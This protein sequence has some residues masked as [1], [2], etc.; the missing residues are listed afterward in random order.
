[1]DK[2]NENIK[3]EPTPEETKTE[4]T[5]ETKKDFNSMINDVSDSTAEMDAKDIE[6]GKVMGILSYLG[7]L[8]LIPYFA[9]KNNKFVVFH[10]KEGLNLLIISVIFTFATGV[11][12]AIP[13]IGLISLLISWVGSLAILALSILGIVNVCQGKAKELPFINKIKLIK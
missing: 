4:Q 1:M 7:I 3:T 11:I 12:S 2:E 5:Q 8:C 9:E 13:L 10:A 6:N